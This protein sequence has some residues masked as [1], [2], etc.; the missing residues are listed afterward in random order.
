MAD[1]ARDLG[2][3]LAA[4]R[5]ASDCKLQDLIDI[6]LFQALQDKLDT[7]YSFPSA[8]IDNDG[9]VLTA[10]AWQDVC[11]RFHRMHPE[12]AKECVASD[13]YIMSHLSEANPA[14]TY[15]CPHGLVDNATPIIVGGRHLGN[16]FTGQFFLEPPDLEFFRAQARTYG[17]DEA[18]YLDA[19]ARVPVWSAEKL[20]Q[21]LDFIKGFTEILA[22][23]GHRQLQEFESRRLALEKGSALEE[24][25]VFNQQIVDSVEEGV[26]VYGPDLRYR[27]WNPYME[28]LSGVASSEVVGRHPTDVFPFLSEMGMVDRLAAALRGVSQPAFNIPFTT[29]DG[30]SGWSSQVCGPLYG[31]DGVVI[32]VIATVRE[33]TSLIRSEAETRALQDQ[34][35]HSQ[36]ME[37]VGRLAGGVA[38]DFNNLLSVIIGHTD[39]ALEQVDPGAALHADL[40]E[41]QSAAQRS[42]ELTKQLLAFARRQTAAPK[43][44]DVNDSIGGM[45][46]MLR[47]MIGEDIDLAWIPGWNVGSIRIDPSQL[48]QILANLCVNARDAIDGNGKVTIE[49]LD[50]ELDGQYCALHTDATPGRYMML[51]VTDSGCGM[52]KDIVGNIFEPFFTTKETGKGTGLGLSTVY[53]I[54]KQN[55]GHIGVYSEPGVGTSFKIY[56]PRLS[57]QVDPLPEPGAGAADT[58]GNSRR[59][60]LLVE[61]EPGVLKVGKRLL[62]RL[63]FI[64]LPAGSPTEAMRLAD[65]HAGHIDLLLTDVVMPE[66]NGR[67]LAELLSGRCPG[68]RL[69]FMSGY[70]ANVVARHGVLDGDVLLVEKPITEKDLAA[71]IREVFASP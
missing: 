51:G 36:K 40:L 4:P 57:D 52:S 9:N 63:G 35:L 39:M 24:L 71:K 49:T 66:M 14:V 47:R 30:R 69:M 16:F 61:D 38:H 6:P 64:V 22:G 20:N 55:G 65:Q 32:G 50:I 42:A 59:T 28:R 3:D 44:I 46:K 68:M 5:P 41:I 25:S 70:T 17:F 45:L 18:A 43:V 60:I 33:I 62:E 54:V 56:L 19:V 11:T 2:A 15:R 34:L 29:P 7:I 26:V 27:L 12:C 13:R 21:Y 67:E 58:A 1:S 23:I 37:A 10:T 48:T 8:I 31:H 53:G